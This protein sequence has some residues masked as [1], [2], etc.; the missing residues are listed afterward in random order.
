MANT[1]RSASSSVFPAK[2]RTPFGK[3]PLIVK[4][5]RSMF[6]QRPSLPHYTVTYDVAKMLQYISNSYSKMFFRVSDKK[7]VTLIRILCPQRS[8][9]Y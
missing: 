4:L 7:L 1:A 9:T 5:L 6:K 2:D 8:Q 3:Y